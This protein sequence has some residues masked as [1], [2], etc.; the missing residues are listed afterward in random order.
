[1][2]NE[3]QCGFVILSSRTFENASRCTAKCAF[4]RADGIRSCGHHKTCS[5]DYAPFMNLVTY[6]FA[7]PICHV[8]EGM[9]SKMACGHWFHTSCAIRWKN[10]NNNIMS[11]PICRNLNNEF[12]VRNIPHM[13]DRIHMNT[14]TA[15]SNNSE[16]DHTDSN[17][18]DPTYDPNMV[19]DADED[20]DED[21][22]DTISTNSIE[23]DYE[24]ADESIDRHTEIITTLATVSNT[25]HD[26]AAIVRRSA[27]N[28]TESLR[29]A[30][31]AINT[32][33]ETMEKLV[34]LNN[35]VS[36]LVLLLSQLLTSS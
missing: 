27:E 33:N 32:S 16:T 18:D 4:T 11:C 20:D 1:M 34:S 12:I 2:D 3:A 35:N 21:S 5:I 26:T 14:T 10:Y 30:E 19:H 36:Q 22:S 9:Y 25:I 31:A 28:T 13:M 15:N 17:T 6:D 24:T 8:S 7:C 23:D 29:L